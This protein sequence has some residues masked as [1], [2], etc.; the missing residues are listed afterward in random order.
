MNHSTDL[1]SVADLIKNKEQQILNLENLDPSRKNQLTSVFNED[2][3]YKHP[4]K[5]MEYYSSLVQF[6]GSI[7]NALDQ[8]QEKMDAL[9]GKV[10]PHYSSE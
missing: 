4:I 8:N 1:S 9:S 2:I 7:E 3:H 6:E 10:K 5:M